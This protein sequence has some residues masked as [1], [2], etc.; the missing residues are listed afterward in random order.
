MSS[1]DLTVIG[2][3]LFPHFIGLTGALLL[4]KETIKLMKKLKKP[5]W[6]PPPW[7]CLSINASL[8]TTVGYASYLVYRDGGGFSG[9]A[10]LPLGIYG[11]NVLA[12]SAWSVIFVKVKRFDIALG[13]NQLIKAT[14]FAMC[15]HFYEV[16]PI[17][18][19]L[20]VPYC[21]VTC[22]ATV[23]FYKIWRENRDVS[24]ICF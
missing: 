7:M 1:T 20:V 21:L 9:R 12:N 18:G 11:M 22:G 24:K 10:K 19:Y 6:T 17:A 14:A 3:T 13:A 5:S 8:C 4:K 16:N 2:F 23:F 15:Y